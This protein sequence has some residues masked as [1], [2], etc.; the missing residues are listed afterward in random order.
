MKIHRAAAVISG[1]LACIIGCT[2]DVQTT[3]D[4]TRVTVDAPKVE[5][6]DRSPDLDPTT[7]NDVDVDTPL[8]GDR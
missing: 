7:D 5:T 4:S 6:G 8:P 1:L 2:A 3:E